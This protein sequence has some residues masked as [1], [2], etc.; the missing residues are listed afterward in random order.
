VFPAMFRTRPGFGKV[1]IRIFQ[2]LVFVPVAY[3]ALKR[4]LAAVVFLYRSLM[5]IA[6]WVNWHSV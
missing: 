3:L 6:V 1:A 2:H 4:S 5:G